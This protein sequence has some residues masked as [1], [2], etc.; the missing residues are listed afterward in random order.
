MFN[1]QKAEVEV[2]VQDVELIGM[3]NLWTKKKLD[4]VLIVVVVT[5]LATAQME[6]MIDVSIAARRDTWRGIVENR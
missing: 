6:E 4:L 2:V 1:G 3:I 5:G